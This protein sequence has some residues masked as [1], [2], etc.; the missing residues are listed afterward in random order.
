[1]KVILLEKFKD[2]GSVGDLV[3]VKSGYARNFLVPNQKA[4]FAT[5]Q[6]VADFETKKAQLIELSKKREAEA[7]KLADKIKNQIVAAIKQAGD[8]GRLYGAVTS[9]D[10]ADGLNKAS[11][12][13][14]DRKQIT[15]STSIK[16]IGFYPVYVD[17]GEGVTAQIYVN[18][19]RSE[20]EAEEQKAKFQ[21]GKLKAGAIAAEADAKK[22]PAPEQ[23]AEKSE[24]AAA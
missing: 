19:A 7:N 2:L 8:D 13:Q 18:V 3:D 6:N 16:S 9:G 12:T 1:M 22:K 23:T 11:G 10:I 15:V 5:K 4:V 21:A 20:G 24:E 14:I 17:L